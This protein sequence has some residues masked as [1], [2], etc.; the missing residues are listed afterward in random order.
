MIAGGL[1]VAPVPRW[2][3]LRVKGI[4]IQTLFRFRVGVRG[5]EVR[6]RVSVGSGVIFCKFIIKAFTITG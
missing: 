6:A 1:G 3:K 4:R 5:V 2:N